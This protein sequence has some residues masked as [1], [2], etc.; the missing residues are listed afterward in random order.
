MDSFYYW[1]YHHMN[2]TL[3]LQKDINNFIESR[4]KP[5]D[6]WETFLELKQDIES[7]SIN[8]LEYFPMFVLNERTNRYVKLTKERFMQITGSECECG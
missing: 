6:A 3:D 8:G 1:W 4:N 7:Q 2:I 5:K